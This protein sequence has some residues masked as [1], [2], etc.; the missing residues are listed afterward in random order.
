[1]LK[2]TILAVTIVFLSYSPTALIAS[3]PTRT[4]NQYS[5]KE[6]ADHYASISQGESRYTSA[7]IACES[8]YEPTSKGDGGRANNVGQFHKPTFERLSKLM[9]EELD[10]NS[11]YDQ[12]KL[13]AWSLD[14]GY[15]A[16]WTA[17]RAIKNGGT[18]SFYSKLLQ[19]H[20]TATCRA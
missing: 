11:Y 1:M 7:V 8:R 6:L 2:L 18:Y 3:A 13:L 19:K 12:T 10:Y 16:N 14:N 4:L 17:Y 15:G 20:Y 5:P 9:G